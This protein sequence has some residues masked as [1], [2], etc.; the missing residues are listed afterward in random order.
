MC[1]C[2]CCVCIIA[3]YAD[4]FHV[5]VQFLKSV[6]EKAGLEGRI[7]E[8]PQNVV[9]VSLTIMARN[10]VVTPCGA[11]CGQRW[12]LRFNASLEPFPLLLTDAAGVPVPVQ[13][14]LGIAWETLHALRYL[15]CR[16]L[17]CLEELSEVL[18][19]VLMQSVRV[20][21]CV[22][23]CLMSVDDGCSIDSP[24]MMCLLGLCCPQTLLRPVSGRNYIVLSLSSGPFI[25]FTLHR[26]AITTS[27]CV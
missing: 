8:Y 7:S 25:I 3:F 1:V 2:V 18:G 10:R 27:G 14:M 13:P 15:I 4:V 22:A 16:R 11:A 26:R 21:F 23:E 5:T 20:L 9:V 24:S 17:C 6:M 19:I 12:L